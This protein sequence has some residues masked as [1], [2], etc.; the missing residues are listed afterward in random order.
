MKYRNVYSLSI[1]SKGGL[2]SESFSLWL[3]SQKKKVPNYCPEHYPRKEKTL[4]V[5]IWHPFFKD[6]SHSEKLSE[7]KPP[8]VLI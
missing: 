8:L 3:K 5:V 4:R 1:Y 6:L 2:F 7:I